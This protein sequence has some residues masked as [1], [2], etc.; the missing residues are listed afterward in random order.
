MGADIG[1][2]GMSC[3]SPPADGI[4]RDELRLR[5]R[6]R[7]DERRLGLYCTRGMRA[8]QMPMLGF[9]FP[10]SSLVARVPTQ[11]CA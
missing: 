5:L 6:L 1:E 11:A 4:A 10:T 7:L 9:P 3:S 8:Q 2:H